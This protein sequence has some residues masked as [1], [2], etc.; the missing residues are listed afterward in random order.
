MAPEVALRKD[1]S[2]LGILLFTNLNLD[3]RL[4]DLP[5]IENHYCDQ[6]SLIEASYCNGI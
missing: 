6:L 1:S 3:K 5:L 2:L 4:G